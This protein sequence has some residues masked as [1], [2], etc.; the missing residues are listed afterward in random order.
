MAGGL[1]VLFIRVTGA[2][3][4]ACEVGALG[5]RRFGPG[6]YGYV[7]SA[8]GPGGYARLDRHAATASGEQDTCH[9]H[10]DYLL[11]HDRTRLADVVRL[12]DREDECGLAA[13]VPGEPVPAFG[14]SDCSC[15]AHLF[16]LP[17]RASAAAA[18]DRFADDGGER[19]ERGG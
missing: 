19:S 8:H 14:A 11:A 4:V 18:I 16:A 1:Y 2:R 3:P 15:E 7:G 5:T 13:A 6:L 17:D 12:P 9:W 10:I